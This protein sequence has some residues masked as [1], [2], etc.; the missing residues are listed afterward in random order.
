E[1]A[2]A[3]GATAYVPGT[4]GEDWQYGFEAERLLDHDT[5]RLGQVTL[6]ARHTPGHTPEHLSYLV[7]DGAFAD[8]PGYILTGD[9]VF[10]GDLRSPPP[11]VRP[12]TCP[13]P[14]VRTGSTASRPS[15]CSITTRSGWARSRSPP[16][17][18]RATLPST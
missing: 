2:A 13:A 9:F 3:T 4:G 10:S 18:P 12:P 8:E 7:T 17:T 1:L 15:A 14:A 6:T 16:A 11:P 5:I